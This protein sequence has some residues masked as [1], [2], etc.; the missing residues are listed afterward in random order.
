MIWEEGAQRAYLVTVFMALGRIFRSGLVL[1]TLD[2]SSTL[3][4]HACNGLCT[5][6]WPLSRVCIHRHTSSA[7]PAT[8]WVPVLGFGVRRRRSSAQ[9]EVGLGGRGAGS[10]DVFKVQW[11]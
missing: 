2:S 11:L 5:H 7:Q 3:P 9:N 8:L 6:G 1:A 10:V 4:F